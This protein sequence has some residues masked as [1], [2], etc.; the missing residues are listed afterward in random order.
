MIST[1]EINNENRILYSNFYIFSVISSFLS[2]FLILLLKFFTV[3]INFLLNCKSLIDET[4]RFT[5][6]KCL[7]IPR[8][9]HEEA[10]SSLSFLIIR[11]NYGSAPPA[12]RISRFFLSTEDRDVHRPRNSGS[13]SSSFESRFYR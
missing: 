1:Q 13:P 4:L 12:Q 9:V 7:S 8:Q 3:S 11:H 10:S 6:C 5:A 2:I